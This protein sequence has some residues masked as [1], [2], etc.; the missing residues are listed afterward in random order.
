[1]AGLGGFLAGLR[2]LGVDMSQMASDVA[3]GEAPEQIAAIRFQRCQTCPEVDSQGVPI[4][5]VR[6]IPLYGPLLFCGQP[7]WAGLGRDP[8]ADGCGC[9]LNAKVRL[10]SAHC[11]RG[12][13]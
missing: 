13:W 4:P 12:R 3:S 9:C 6:N 7:R 11:P 8:V 1:M 5:N 10:T 2:S